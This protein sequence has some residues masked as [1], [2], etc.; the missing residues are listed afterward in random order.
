[1]EYEESEMETNEH[2]DKNEDENLLATQ[3]YSYD[4][5]IKQRK[6]TDGAA[7][8]TDENIEKKKGK[9]DQGDSEKR[10]NT[11]S[12]AIIEEDKSKSANKN[13]PSNVECSSKTASNSGIKG[14][15]ISVM[16]KGESSHK[17]VDT[18]FKLLKPLAETPKS[19]GR[20][21]DDAKEK[22]KTLSE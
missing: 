12:K 1:M 16:E 14:S 22:V 15:S 9:S 7:D 11:N 21:N 4:I 13:S 17:K 2:T 3:E 20:G 18:G 8:T 5:R 6:Q 19:R 10:S